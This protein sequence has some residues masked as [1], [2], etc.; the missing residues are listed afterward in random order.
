MTGP[1]ARHKALNFMGLPLHP[2]SPL[3]P[4]HEQKA[5]VKRLCRGAD[6]VL[7]RPGRGAP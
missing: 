7:S 3:Q 5:G 4:V 2:D 6:T 1:G